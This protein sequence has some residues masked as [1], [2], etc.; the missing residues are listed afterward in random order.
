MKTKKNNMEEI[1]A[2]DI[3]YTF[4]HLSD[5]WCNGL[6]DTKEECIKEARIFLQNNKAPI[7]YIAECYKEKFYPQLDFDKLYEDATEQYLENTYTEKEWVD[8]S[9]I[10][11]RK[12]EAHLNQSIKDFIDN[13]CPKSHYWRIEVI[14]NITYSN[15]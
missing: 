3:K 4:S 5:E 6:Y 9:N 8:L 2:G 7:V 10:D 12:F 15:H 13:H 1:K 14:D 11:T